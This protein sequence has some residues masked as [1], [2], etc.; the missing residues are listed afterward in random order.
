LTVLLVAVLALI[1]VLSATAQRPP[2]TVALIGDSLLA[3]AAPLISRDVGPQGT[4]VVASLAV[5]GA[6]ILDTSVNWLAKARQLIETEDPN[7][8][9]VE[10]VGNYG[11][12]GS[13]PGISVY[14]APFYRRWAATAQKLEYILTSRGAAVYWVV[15]PPVRI[16]GPERGI[17]TFDRIYAHLH[18]PNTRSTTPLLIDVTPAVTG[19]T[20][21]Y[22]Q[23]VT[24]AHGTRVQVRQSDGVH[25]TTYGASLF[26]RAIADVVG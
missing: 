16:A 15:G 2:E 19:G 4:R 13:I 1:G 3:E 18:A 23:Y 21:S 11:T 9:V 12:Y 5:E 10:Y 14:T 8:V 7:A 17:E 20:G 6:G 24:G 26:A 25:F 22:T